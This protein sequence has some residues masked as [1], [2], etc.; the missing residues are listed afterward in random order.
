MDEKT[1]RET[2]ARVMA[3]LGEVYK[4]RMSVTKDSMEI[5]WRLF[6]GRDMAE[7][8]RA[9][10]SHMTDPERGRWPPT[11]SDI[12]A[13]MDG[14]RLTPD[15]IIAEARLAITPL[16]ILA[17]L[18]I[19][20]HDLETASPVHLRQRA[21]EVALMQDEWKARIRAGELTEHEK[22]TMAKYNVFVMPALGSTPQI[23]GES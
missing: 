11:P 22:K 19:G 5:W 9:A 4:G 7:F 17:R 18:H 23:G 21:H 14:N 2:F 15:E 13:I 20:T 8:G 12:I 1:Q 10:A 3:G 6:K 16:G